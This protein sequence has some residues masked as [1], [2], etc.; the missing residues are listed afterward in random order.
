[1]LLAAVSSLCPDTLNV[2]ASIKVLESSPYTT[3]LSCHGSS[4]R[5][6]L[7]PAHYN[8]WKAFSAFLSGKKSRLPSCVS[9]GSSEWTMETQS[10][11]S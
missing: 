7:S 8:S 5:L 2:F 6:V 9:P 10:I 4:P 11:S 1:M 3:T